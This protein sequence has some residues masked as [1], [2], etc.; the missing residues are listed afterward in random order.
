[1][2]GL[3]PAL[4]ALLWAGGHSL[5]PYKRIYPTRPYAKEDG[6][7]DRNGLA[8]TKPRFTNEAGLLNVY[9]KRAWAYFLVASDSFVISG[10]VMSSIPS[11]LS[12]RLMAGRP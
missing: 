6:E 1:M 9:V 4:H 5:I 8:K 7:L 12:I 11:M 10:S 3:D 2:T